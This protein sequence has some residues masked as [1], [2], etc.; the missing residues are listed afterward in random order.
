MSAKKRGRPKAG[1][2]DITV[3]LDYEVVRRARVVAELEGKP[4]NKYLTDI[5]GPI[6]TRDLAAALK[7]L[8][9]PK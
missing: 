6:V 3:K 8:D 4:L 9:E 5:L 1:R 7:K 2:N